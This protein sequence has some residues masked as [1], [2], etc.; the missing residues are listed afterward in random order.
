MM[1]IADQEIELMISSFRWIWSQSLMKNPPYNIKKN[2][3]SI[4]WQI[5]AY[6]QAKLNIGLGYRA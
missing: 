3:I 5:D 1:R 6:L 4:Y 2:G